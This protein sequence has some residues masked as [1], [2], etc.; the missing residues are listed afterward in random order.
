VNR[1]KRQNTGKRRRSSGLQAPVHDTSTQVA[2]KQ[3]GV[4]SHML[5]NAGHHDIPIGCRWSQNSCAYDCL[6]TAMFSLW[7]SDREHWTQALKGMGNAVTDLLLHGF[8][9]YETAEISLEKARDDARHLI[10]R[11]RNS[12]PFGV[13][14]SIEN[15]CTQLLSTDKVVSE[16]YYNCPNGHD[17]L[18]SYDYNAILCR[19][20]CQHL[21]ISLWMSSELYHA[22]ARCQTCRHA[23]GIKLRFCYSPPLLAFSI[24]GSSL[25]IDPTFNLLVEYHVCRYT[26]IAVVYY[27]DL[28]FTAQIVT[29]DGR[30][31]YYDGLAIANESVLP[32][33][34]YAASMLSQPDMLTCKG[35]LACVAIYTKV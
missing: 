30:I 28:H 1:S 3:R 21:S 31:W 33:L 22:H 27:A 32:T 29:R 25:H 5:L 9:S 16:R 35:S 13:N 18:H 11:R 7:C 26:L 10:A 12:T 6:F 23:V 2:R 15:V 8:S 34:K 4:P 19:G 24:S 17:I 20:V 14:T